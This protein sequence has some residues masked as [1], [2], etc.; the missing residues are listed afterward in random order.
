MKD[1]ITDYL[2]KLWKQ[3]VGSD[4]ERAKAIYDYICSKT[5]EEL[6]D[7]VGYPEYDSFYLAKELR[8]KSYCM[9]YNCNVARFV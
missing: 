2:V 5:P 1:Y 3:Q 6:K 4:Y 7:E 8:Y 9:W